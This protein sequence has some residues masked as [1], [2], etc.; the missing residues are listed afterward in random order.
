MTVKN[1]GCFYQ[2][3]D[4]AVDPEHQGKGYGKLIMS[5]LMTYMDGHA[6][7]GAYISLIADVPADRLY[8]KFGFAYTSPSSVGMY[9]KYPL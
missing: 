8:S 6:P 1:G 7:R 3:V 2:V 5:E 4:I 9:K